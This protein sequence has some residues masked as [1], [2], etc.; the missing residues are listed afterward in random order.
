MTTSKCTVALLVDESGHQY[1][2]LIQR[3]A[4]SSTLDDIKYCNDLSVS[5]TS[6]ATHR[7]SKTSIVTTEATRSTLIE[8]LASLNSYTS[9]AYSVAYHLD[10]LKKVI[11]H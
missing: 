5:N 4:V 7:D 6:T 1:N 9:V 2:I 8:L 11:I 3:K 10:I